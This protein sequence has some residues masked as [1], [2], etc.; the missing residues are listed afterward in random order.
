LHHPAYRDKY[1]ENF[2]RELPRLPLVT[3]FENFGKFADIGAKLCNLHLNYEAAPEYSARL[4]E[5]R[6]VPFSWRV[7]KM[8]LSRDKSTLTVNESLSIEGIPAE[9]FDY[10]L[11]NRSALEWIIDQYQTKTDARSGLSSDPNREDDE[12][13]IV[14]L[15][16]RVMTV[17]LETMKLIGELPDAIP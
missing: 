7:Q 12:E 5:N 9:V 3:G 8:K 1:A 14:R 13:Y 11:G 15:A 2:K 17:S 4:V 6:E 16:Q 10:R